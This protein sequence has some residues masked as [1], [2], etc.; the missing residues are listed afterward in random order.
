MKSMDIFGGSLGITYGGD[1]NYKT[2]CGGCFTCVYILLIIVFWFYY[3][4]KFINSKEA[5]VVVRSLSVSED[6]PEIDF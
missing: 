3:L 4:E 5:P 1:D 2:K 6:Y